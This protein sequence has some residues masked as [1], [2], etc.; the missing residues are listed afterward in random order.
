MELAR[1]TPVVFFIKLAPW[2]TKAWR[3]A[4]MPP[5]CRD[6]W[7]HRVRQDDA[8]VNFIKPAP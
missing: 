7:R 1:T 3:L 4:R 8:S 5:P 6:G 2:R